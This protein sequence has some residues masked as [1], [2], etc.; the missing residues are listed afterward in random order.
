ML[1]L[2]C[3]QIGW[4]FYLLHTYTMRTRASVLLLYVLTTRGCSNNHSTDRPTGTFLA[5]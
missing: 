1:E 3:I 5:K 4:P 2:L